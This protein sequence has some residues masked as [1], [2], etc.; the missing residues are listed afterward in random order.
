M[1]KLSRLFGKKAIYDIDD[2]YS[3]VK[4]KITLKNVCRIMSSATAVTVGSENLLKFASKYQQKVYY[5]PTSVKMENYIVPKNKQKNNTVR[6]GWIGNGRGYSKDLIEILKEPLSA[7]ANRYKVSL[8][9]VGVCGQ[10]DLYEAFSNIP[11]LDTIFIDNLNWSDPYEISKALS[12][13]DIGL[14]PILNNQFNLH[15]CGFKALEYMAMKI[16]VIVSPVGANEYIVHDNVEGYHAKDTQEWI[17][18]MSELIS[19]V[20]RREKMGAAGRIEVERHYNIAL[21]SRKLATIIMEL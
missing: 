13:F 21:T 11:G 16:P 17:E 19:N 3:K 9:L 6:L 2:D 7:I 15:K 5:L 18:K 20:D 4:S 14:Y 1:L 12:S 8:S 10:K